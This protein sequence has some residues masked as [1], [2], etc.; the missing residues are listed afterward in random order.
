MRWESLHTR[1]FTTDAGPRL[2]RVPI[3]DQSHSPLLAQLFGD[4]RAYWLTGRALIWRHR[5]TGSTFHHEPKRERYPYSLENQGKKRA[6][7][8]PV[9]KSYYSCKT[10]QQLRKCEM[11]MSI[12]IKVI[13]KKPHYCSK[14]PV[15]YIKWKLICCLKC[16]KTALYHSYFNS[17]VNHSYLMNT[18][19]LLVTWNFSYQSTSL[20]YAHPLCKFG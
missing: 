4:E 14:Y 19:L 5:S 2:P 17:K 9:I 10:D 1:S 15:F 20:N 8:L 3:L 16:K 18:L 13:H 11:K 7:I 6:R 12:K